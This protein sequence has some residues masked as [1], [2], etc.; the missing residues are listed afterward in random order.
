MNVLSIV[1]YG[2]ISGRRQVAEAG[3]D[4]VNHVSNFRFEH[5]HRIQADHK[6]KLAFNHESIFR[7]DSNKKPSIDG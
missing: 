1:H 7:F 5:A 6:S 4:P 3:T 2:W